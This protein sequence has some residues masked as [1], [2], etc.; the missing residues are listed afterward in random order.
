MQMT[1]S[2]FW[3]RSCPIDDLLPWLRLPI[4]T[5]PLLSCDVKS[6]LQRQHRV[7]V[8][9]KFSILKR[10]LQLEIVHLFFTQVKWKCP[11]EYSVVARE[12]TERR[13][14]WLP[15]FAKGSRRRRPTSHTWSWWQTAP[16]WRPP[17]VERQKRALIQVFRK[18]SRALLGGD[19][20][21]LKCV[22]QPKAE[23]P[24]YVGLPVG[25]EEHKHPNKSTEPDPV[26]VS[27]YSTWNTCSHGNKNWKIQKVKNTN[28]RNQC[29]GRLQV[30]QNNFMYF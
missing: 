29:M 25:T 11:C 1:S 19:R 9:H 26:W 16:R 10:Q 15:K 12:E 27:S 5:F 18:K 21:L 13:R 6:S 4:F 3:A 24:W 8:K 14:A 2:A 28:V 7:K 23:G 22:L 30:L 17:W 20:V